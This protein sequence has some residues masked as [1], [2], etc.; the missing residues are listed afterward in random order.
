MKLTKEQ[1][2]ILNKCIAE[3]YKNKDELVALLKLEMDITFA[4]IASGSTYTTEVFNL[5]E[6]L[7][8]QGNLVEFITKVLIDRPKNPYL[9]NVIEE[10]QDIV[11][12]SL[13]EQKIL[14]SNPGKSYTTLDIVKAFSLA[15]IIEENKISSCTSEFKDNQL[16][17]TLKKID[18]K[19]IQEIYRDSLPKNPSID[20]GELMD[21]VTLETLIQILIIE[22]P[23]NQDKKPTILE[24][25]D[26]LIK[27]LINNDLQQELYQWRKHIGEHN[28]L[29][30][31]IPNLEAVEIIKSDKILRYFLQI[32]V[33][34]LP[35]EKDRFILKAL[36]IEDRNPEQNN[37]TIINIDWLD[38]EQKGF[39]FESVSTMINK[40]IQSTSQKHLLGK[41]F[42]LLIE[43]F[44]PISYLSKTLDLEEVLDELDC[45]ERLG[46]QY[47]L[48]VRSYDRT[49][50][51]T[52]LSLLKQRWK[53]LQNK[54]QANPNPEAWE[55]EFKTPPVL[56][57]KKWSDLQ[58]HLNEKVGLKICS[59]FPTTPKDQDELFK[60]ILRTG[61]PICLWSR[62]KSLKEDEM[63]RF[64]QLLSLEQVRDINN[65]YKAIFELRKEVPS[66]KNQA[67]NH[68]GS[69]LGFLC[70]HGERIP[71]ISRLTRMV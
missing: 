37:E 4:L 47:P 49:R 2:K 6:Y 16:L 38:S 32:I 20:I 52:L 27:R 34:P 22:F 1:R 41:I 54:I 26:K 59:N 55:E 21:F 33:E 25:T 65:L 7:E 14:K 12:Q 61:V 67:K 45:S 71:D 48:I 70:D 56:A 9:Q 5:I 64:N 15:R 68:L 40:I 50:A 63:V 51:P 23:L 43:V 36:L 42:N 17:E 18:F 24:F 31:E 39:Y 3:A 29:T 28:N 62:K 8:I 58:K 11:I 66:S 60:T 69:H 35:T 13:T 44:L 19:L 10:F 46:K 30:F 53:L 57:D